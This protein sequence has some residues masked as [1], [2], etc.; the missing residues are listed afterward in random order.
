MHEAFLFIAG[1]RILSLQLDLRY[2]L[3]ISVRGSGFHEVAMMKAVMVVVASLAWATPLAAQNVSEPAQPPAAAQATLLEPKKDSAP[4]HAHTGWATLFKDTARD[5]V[6]FPQR[7]STWAIV[8]IGAAAALATHPA[9][10]YVE[11]HIVGSTAA[12]RAFSVGKWAGSTYLQVGSG[13]GL[14]A[15]GRYVIAPAT[16]ESQ[17]NKYS[18]IGF[19]LI[20]AQIV[21][22]AIVHGMKYS[23]GRNRPSGECCSF[24]SGHSATAFAVASVLERHLGYRASWPALAGAMYVATS[25]LVDNRHFLSDVMMGAGIGTAAG[26]TVVGTRGRSGFALQPVPVKGGMMLAFMRLRDEK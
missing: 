10:T 23:I 2:C 25:R 16:N 18:E 21:S 6:N 15:I 8:G 14:W 26:W 7:K 1:R 19:D 4:E 20:R 24:P 9:D 11:S 17:T 13:V 3:C 12:E 5:F 22:Q